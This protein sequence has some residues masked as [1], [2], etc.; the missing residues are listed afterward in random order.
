MHTLQTEEQLKSIT[1]KSFVLSAPNL[2]SVDEVIVSPGVH[3]ELYRFL[4]DFFFGSFKGSP[5]F[6]PFCSVGEMLEEVEEESFDSASLSTTGEYSSIYPTIQDF[7]RAVISQHGD[8][9]VIVCSH[10]Q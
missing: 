4:N 1:D 8:N 2:K 6:K 9:A 5:C 7:L 3:P 10:Y